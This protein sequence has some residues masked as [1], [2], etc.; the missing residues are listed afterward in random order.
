LEHW[1]NQKELISP[2]PLVSAALLSTPGQE[3]FTEGLPD[4]KAQHAIVR[5][6]YFYQ[7]SSV[8][9][10]YEV[11]KHSVV[12]YIYKKKQKKKKKVITS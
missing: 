6:L 12:Y 9:F 3:L 10:F 7:I 8:V 11:V 4:L 2:S 5:T 1:S